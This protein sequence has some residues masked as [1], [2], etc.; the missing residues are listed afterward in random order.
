MHPLPTGSGLCVGASRENARISPGR[1]QADTRGFAGRASPRASAGSPSKAGDIFTTC[2]AFEGCPYRPAGGGSARLSCGTADRLRAEQLG[3]QQRPQKLSSA[4]SREEQ[5]EPQLLRQEEKKAHMYNTL[6]IFV[7]SVW[8]ERIV[9]ENDRSHKTKSLPDPAKPAG[10]AGFLGGFGGNGKNPTA[11][12]RDGDVFLRG[13]W[14]LR[15]GRG[16]YII[17]KSGCADCFRK[18]RQEYAGGGTR[19]G[20]P[21]GFFRREPAASDRRRGERRTRVLRRASY[22]PRGRGKAEADE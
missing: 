18:R 2:P 11:C 13:V 10:M 6:Q 14:V 7:G 3:A 19:A 5:S 17:G 8:D 9:T 22:L 16:Y 1:G 4:A 20:P 21:G 12:R 15:N